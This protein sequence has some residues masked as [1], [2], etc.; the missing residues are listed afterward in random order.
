MGLESSLIRLSELE[1]ETG[2]LQPSFGYFFVGGVNSS[3]GSGKDSTIMH[4]IGLFVQVS[5][6]EVN[7]IV[8]ICSKL[9]VVVVTC[10]RVIGVGESNHIVGM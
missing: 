5:V 10:R 6:D 2:V 3:V 7:E 1:K 9:K 4:K 8:K